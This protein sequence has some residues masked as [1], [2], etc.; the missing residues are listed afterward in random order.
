[1][2]VF[3]S[4]FV[5]VDG[6]NG[7]VDVFSFENF[8]YICTID[9]NEEVLSSGYFSEEVSSQSPKLYLATK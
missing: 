3:Q 5:L 4:R 6:L 2:L 1:M 9:I 8:D 7:N